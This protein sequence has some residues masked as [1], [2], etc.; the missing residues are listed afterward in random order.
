MEQLQRGEGNKIIPLDNKQESA[1]KTPGVGR[2]A[3]V[4]D[5]DEKR[6]E[7]K[8]KLE[9]VET[10]EQFKS[11]IDEVSGRYENLP[12]NIRKSF[13][14]HNEGI[15]C[16]AIELGIRNGFSREELEQLKL[17]AI[18]HDADKADGIPEE[19]KDIK[20]YT[21]VMHAKIASEKIP[22]ILTDE[23]L[24]KMG[25]EGDFEKI[26]GEVARA[27]LEHMGPIPGFM[28]DEIEKF[29]KKMEE[30]GGER[31]SY[32]E[33]NGK[34]SEALLAA[35]MRSLASVDG[36]NKVL[37]LRSVAPDFIKEDFDSVGEYKKYEINLIQGEAALISGFKSAFQ[38]RD[39]QKKEEYQN[40]INEEIEKSK[41]VKYIFLGEEIIWEDVESKIAEYEEKKKIEEV[42]DRLKVA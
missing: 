37:L 19:Y 34:I 12:D 11:L 9:I 3:E 14:K 27:V 28:A 36:I 25:V 22:E 21:L 26:R 2:N 1:P 33:A 7:K 35:D 4:I 23:K 42:R 38:A 32:P 6:W 18:L 30:K 16:G 13:I 15:L 20:N 8:I 24:E 40:W 10:K 29:N 5:L 31:I 41:T 39:M 17:S